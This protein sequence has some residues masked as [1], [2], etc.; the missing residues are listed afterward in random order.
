M[1]VRAASLGQIALLLRVVDRV[2][3][4]RVSRELRARA[5]DGEPT[6][7]ARLLLEEGV[8]VATLEE[9]FARGARLAAVRC[10]GCGDAI[11]QAVLPGRRETPCA[12]CG[13][14]VLGFRAYDPS[15]EEELPEAEPEEDS[16]TLAHGERR[17]PDQRTIPY[18]RVL[19]TGGEPAFA[20]NKTIEFGAILDIP[21]EEAGETPTMTFGNVLD[22]PDHLQPRSVEDARAAYKSLVELES[23][24]PEEEGTTVPVDPGA[25]PLTPPGVEK[26]QPRPMAVQDLAPPPTPTPDRDGAVRVG[27]FEVV[28][29]LGKGSMGRVLLCRQPSLD[30][31]VAVKVLS[32]SLTS[33]DEFL[34]RFRREAKAVSDAA[35]ENVVAVIDAGFDVGLGVHYI[36]FEYVDG[37][38]LNHLLKKRAP[39]PEEEATRIAL[40]VARALAFTHSRGIV[41]RDIKPAN[42]LISSRGV[43]KLADLGL[44][45]FIDHSTRLTE[46]GIVLGTPAYLAPEQ[47]LNVEDIDIRADM[48]ALGVV[49]WEML[50]GRIPLDDPRVSTAHLIDLHVDEDVPDVR[51][52][53]PDVSDGVAQVIRHLTARE[54]DARYAEPA[55]AVADLERVL[56]SETPRG[57]G[58]HGGHPTRALGDS[59]PARPRDA[60][61]DSTRPRPDEAGLTA[62][63]VDAP[64][65][66]RR[67]AAPTE[68]PGG[69]SGLSWLLAGLFLGVFVVVAAAVGWLVYLHLTGRELPF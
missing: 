14:L 13:S 6:S 29:L 1:P 43:P 48:Y 30:R 62:A 53:K 8:P 7:Y 26:L 44:A 4:R 25:P 49:L 34:E 38:P 22:V 40:G 63:T 56:A 17:V 2:Q 39:L 20:L 61:L 50:V 12:G 41:H 69:R 15:D 18:G 37:G 24:D 42:I 45:R 16:R 64:P 66:T 9:L 65:P 11:P 46:P 35:H 67:R 27:Q 32:P 3:H 57:P 5:V 55:A 68:H 51:L 59:D 33:S 23:A 10:D 31:L 54:R 21:A 19:A 60:G 58:S 47:A 52:E 28:R 36:A